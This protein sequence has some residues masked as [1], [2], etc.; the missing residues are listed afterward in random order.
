MRFVEELGVDGY[1]KREMAHFT[2]INKILRNDGYHT[3]SIMEYREMQGFPVWKRRYIRHVSIVSE[4]DMYKALK[5][6]ANRPVLAAREKKAIK[7]KK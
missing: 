5:L 4:E 3:L 6:I 1:G 2:A 7:K